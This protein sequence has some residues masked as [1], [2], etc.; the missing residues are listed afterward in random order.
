MPMMG[1]PKKP[2]EKDKGIDMIV[3]IGEP[4]RPPSRFGEDPMPP[5]KPPMEEMGMGG[6]DMKCPNCGCPLK[7]TPQIEEEEP[8]EMGEEPEYKEAS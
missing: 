8:E 6:A 3:A 4:K 5:R 7:V 2:G 1:P